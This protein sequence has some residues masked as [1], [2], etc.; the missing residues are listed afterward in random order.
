MAAHAEEVRSLVAGLGDVDPVARG[1]EVA[2][3]RAQYAQTVLQRLDFALTAVEAEIAT[4]G[5]PTA[6]MMTAAPM[7]LAASERSAG[8]VPELK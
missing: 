6:T 4:S 2:R 5:P 1:I 7:L 3:Q 8:E